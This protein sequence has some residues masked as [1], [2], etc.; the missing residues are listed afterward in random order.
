[1]SRLISKHSVI[2]MSSSL[3][4]SSNDNDVVSVLKKLHQSLQ[5]MLS[6]EGKFA[7]G[8]KETQK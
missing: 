4:L 8:A 7:L 5:T 6:L 1:M 2:D 3:T